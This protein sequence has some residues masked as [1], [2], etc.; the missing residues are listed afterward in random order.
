MD[1]KVHTCV[2]LFF[3]YFLATAMNNK[4]SQTFHKFD[5]NVAAHRARIPVFDHYQT[6]PVPFTCDH[7]FFVIN[8]YCNVVVVGGG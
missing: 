6:C 5:V 3:H 2:F 1:L 8:L 7:T 4:L